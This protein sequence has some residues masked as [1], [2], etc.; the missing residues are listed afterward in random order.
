MR[1]KNAKNIA[2]KNLMDACIGGVVY[3]FFGYAFAYASPGDGTGNP[4]IGGFDFP[5]N[6]S[7]F[8]AGQYYCAELGIEPTICTLLCASL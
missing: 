2:L 8:N 5:S 4:F 1:A 7:T 6:T 3:W